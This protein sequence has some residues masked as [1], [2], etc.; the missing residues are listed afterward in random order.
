MSYICV[1]TKCCHKLVFNVLPVILPVWVFIPKSKQHVDLFP[2]NK[3]CTRFNS[4]QRVSHG[5]ESERNNS[6]CNVWLIS[7]TCL[8]TKQWKDESS[9]SLFIDLTMGIF[10]LKA[11]KFSQHLCWK[12]PKILNISLLCVN[13]VHSIS[14]H[15]NPTLINS[16][17]F[18]T[19][20]WIASQNSN[21]HRFS[22]FEL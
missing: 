19:F 18:C 16:L 8:L 1:H 9:S 17:F 6:C 21:F 22:R 15:R 5:S 4:A 11:V 10:T 13:S 14:T 20:F 12:K 7:L 3:A 2:S